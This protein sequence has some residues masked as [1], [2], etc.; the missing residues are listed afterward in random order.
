MSVFCYKW[1]DADV[2]WNTVE[3]T[4]RE[5]C[6]IKKITDTIGGGYGPQLKQRLKKLSKEE[7]QVLIELYIRI[8]SQDIDFEKRMNKHKNNTVKVKV[9]DIENFLMEVKN[10]KVNI[11]MNKDKDEL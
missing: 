8:K 6:I 5:F 1:N 10:I 4:W 7:K 2:Y 11:F 9:K 3:L